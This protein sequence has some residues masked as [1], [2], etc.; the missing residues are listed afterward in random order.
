MDSV[1]LGEIYWVVVNRVRFCG[2]DLTPLVA[3]HRCKRGHDDLIG[4]LPARGPETKQQVTGARLHL[5]RGR[6]NHIQSLLLVDESWE[7]ERIANPSAH[8]A[9]RLYRLRDQSAELPSR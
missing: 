1:D 7:S 2:G 5:D 3:F 8:A 6:V 9:E 4:A